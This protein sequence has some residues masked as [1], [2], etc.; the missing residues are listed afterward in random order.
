MTR[1]TEEEL[2]AKSAKNR[3]A[4]EDAAK[5]VGTKIGGKMKQIKLSDHLTHVAH[6]SKTGKV[7]K[8]KPLH[9]AKIRV[10]RK[11]VLPSEHE[12]QAALIAWCDAHPI[13]KNIFSIPNGANK[14]FA[15]AAKFKREGLRPGIPD[16]FLPVA[17]RGFH[18]LFI[19]MKRRRF[20]NVTFQQGAWQAA[21][22]HQGYHCVICYGADEAI[23]V[24][25]GYLKET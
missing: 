25:Q 23:A 18:G 22:V 2:L 15:S 5:D 19:E 3:K 12:E 6:V 17:C 13:A 7:G 11:E 9:D 14:S 1:M 20:A 8:F 4:W 21:L 16:L 24:I 10:S